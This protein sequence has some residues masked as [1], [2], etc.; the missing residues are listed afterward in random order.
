MTV[1]HLHSLLYHSRDSQLFFQ[2]A[3]MLA[4]AQVPPAIKDAIRLGRFSSLRKTDGCVRGIVA[5]DIVRRLV[6]R[7]M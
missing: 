3:E 7:T 2:A 6:A 1:E 4:R 5:G